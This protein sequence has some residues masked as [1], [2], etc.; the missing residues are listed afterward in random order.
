MQALLEKSKEELT[1]ESLVYKTNKCER[2]F[3]HEWAFNQHYTTRTTK[4]TQR[5]IQSVS[6]CKWSTLDMQRGYHIMLV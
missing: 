6:L 5:G 2:N 4:A 1:I 3:R